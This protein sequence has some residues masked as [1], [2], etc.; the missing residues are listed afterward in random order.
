MISILSLLAITFRWYHW[1]IIIGLGAIIVMAVILMRVNTRIQM[2]VSFYMDDESGTYNLKGLEKYL[3]KKGRALRNS[4]LVAIELKNLQAVYQFHPNGVELMHNIADVFLRGLGKLDT[5]ARVELNKFIVVLEGRSQDLAKNWC[6]E[7]TEII[8]DAKFDPHVAT[9]F[10]VLYGIRENPD[11]THPATA[12]DETLGIIGFSSMQEGNVYFYTNEVK[13]ALDKS[14]MINKYKE[15][16]LENHEFV[17]YVQ[18]KVSLKTGKVV[19]GEVLCRWLNPDFSVRFY[20]NEFVPVFEH[21]GFIKEIDIE[22]FRQAA[23]LSRNMAA[24][25]FEM[26]I[27]VNVSKQNFNSQEYMQRIM[28]ILSEVGADPTHIEIEIT[29]SAADISSSFITNIVTRFKQF[30]F[31]LAMDDFGKEY[32]S[33]GLLANTPFDVIKMDQVFFKKNLA[34]EKEYLI[35]KNMIKLL[36]KLDVEIVCEGIETKDAIGR[37]AS[38]SKDVVIQGYVYS[39]PITLAEFEA[40]ARKEF[41]VSQYKEIEEEKQ[42][43]FVEKQK[44]NKKGDDSSDEDELTELKAQIEAMKQMLMNNKKED[45]KAKKKAEVSKL[46]EELEQIKKNAKE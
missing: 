28:T 31:K 36:S 29:E 26:D 19:G 1:G 45:A 35:A 38:I 24:K 5:I 46:K 37:L 6:K 3:S 42:V 33:I 30:G 11:Y 15:E 23:M 27:S 20:P 12:I 44:D 39:K 4:C 25:G 14:D 40:F 34:D 10:E 8:N 18:P 41:D 21:G 7:K 17:A 13:S 16:A 2:K 22:M 43:V 32:S 9:K